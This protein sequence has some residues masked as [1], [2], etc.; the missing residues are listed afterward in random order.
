MRKRHTIIA[1]LL[2]T[3]AL[4]GCA[5]ITG[6][7]ATYVA[8]RATV[9]DGTIG[10]TS[11]G[12]ERAEWQN[13][14]RDFEVA[15]RERTVEVSTYV[16]AYTWGEGDR[17]AFAV[18]STPT[19]QVAGQ[20]LNPIADLST[21]EMIRRLNSGFEGKGSLE[22]LERTGE[23]TVTAAG[24]ER[25]VVEF[26]ATAVRNGR[27]ADVVIHVLRFTDGDDIVV[28]AAVHRAGADEVRT[29][30]RTMLSGVEH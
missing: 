27:E 25:T 19:V 15:G 26:S 24:E 21:R 13:R 3:V 17:G 20:T 11:Y 23:Y 1:I 14:S 7:G 8:E 29:D 16:E 10:Q 2:A 28:A 22:D 12:L 5:A 9:A 4:S 6:D 18:L 30:T